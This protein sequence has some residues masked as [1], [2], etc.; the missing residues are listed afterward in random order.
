MRR[1]TYVFHVLF[2]IRPRPGLDTA[3][4]EAAFVHMVELVSQIPGFVS[5][6]GFAAE[7][8]TELAVARFETEEAI[9]IWRDQP[10]HIQTRERGRREFFAAYDITIAEEKHHYD[11]SLDRDGVQPSAGGRQRLAEQAPLDTSALRHGAPTSAG[12]S[13]S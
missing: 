9:R 4:Y 10:D 5:I 7:D 3:A 13:G 8:G 2:Q 1:E 12:G 11:W 6:D